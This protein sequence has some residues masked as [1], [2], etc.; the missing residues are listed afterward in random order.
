VLTNCETICLATAVYC[1]LCSV[2]GAAFDKLTASY[3]WSAIPSTAFST[4][5]TTLCGFPVT[6]VVTPGAV[7]NTYTF[8][9]TFTGYIGDVL[10]TVVYTAQLKAAP[11]SAVQS[12]VSIT[13]EGSQPVRGTFTLVSAVALHISIP[14]R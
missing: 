3:E 12:V 7:S 4:A 6:V 2:G 14:Y 8:D 1:V 10:P 13:T 11:A 9:I 5:F